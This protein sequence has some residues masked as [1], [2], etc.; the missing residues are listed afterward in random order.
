M[1]YLNIVTF[2]MESIGRY[3][4]KP[5][6]RLKLTYSTY[7]PLHPRFLGYATVDKRLLDDDTTF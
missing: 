4:S 5:A 3:I 6:L 1:I 7:I 2:E